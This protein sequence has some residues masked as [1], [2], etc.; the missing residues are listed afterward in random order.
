MT[1]RQRLDA[2]DPRF[3]SFLCNERRAGHWQ[4][5]SAPYLTGIGDR[6]HPQV[7]RSGTMAARLAPYL[8]YYSSKQPSKTTVVSR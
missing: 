1:Q 8:R 4:P 7:V 6:M 5:V 2:A 3:S